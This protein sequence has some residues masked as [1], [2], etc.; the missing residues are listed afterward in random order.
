MSTIDVMGI[1][2]IRSFSPDRQEKITFFKPLTLIVGHNGAGKTTVIEC[3]KMACTGDLPPNVK[4]GQNFI[5]DPKVAGE[6]EVKAQIKLRFQDPSNVSFMVTRSFL[7]SQRR[8]NLQFKALDNALNILDPE[9]NEYSIL[10]QRC[11]NINQQI[12]LTMG[13][14]KA[15]LENVVFVHQEDS[16]WPLSEAANVKKRFDDIFAAT[17]YTKALEEFRKLKVKQTQEAKERRLKLETLKSYRDQ[18]MRLREAIEYSEKNAGAYRDTICKLNDEITDLDAKIQSLN[19]KLSQIARQRESNSSLKVKYDLLLSKNTEMRTLLE[20]KYSTDDL[21]TSVQD[22]EE[23]EAE[24]IPK[25]EILENEVNRADGEISEVQK[26]LHDLI[27]EREVLV[28]DIA[29]LTGE[30][31]SFKQSQNSRHAILSE[32]SKEIG[33]DIMLSNDLNEEEVK[34]VTGLVETSMQSLAESILQLKRSRQMEERVFQENIDA[35]NEKI[36]RIKEILRAKEESVKANDTKTLEIQQN[37]SNLQ[38][39]IGAQARSDNEVQLEMK[40]ISER[41]RRLEDELESRSWDTE[42]QKIDSSLQELGNNIQ[43]LRSDRSKIAAA[44][45]ESSR[46][47]FKIQELEKIKEEESNFRLLHA[48]RLAVLIGI[49]PSNVPKASEELV[50]IVQAKVNEREEYAENLRKRLEKLKHNVSCAENLHQSQHKD[51]NQ[52]EQEFSQIE[53][54]LKDMHSTV[55][56]D[57]LKLHISSLSNRKNIK[58]KEYHFNEASR[59]ILEKEKQYAID[60]KACLACNRDFQSTEERNQFTQEKD[61][62]ISKLP[63]KITKA[64][65]ELSDL[66]KQINDLILVEPDARRYNELKLSIAGLKDALKSSSDNLKKAKSASDLAEESMEKA[67]VSLKESNVIFHEVVLPWSRLLKDIHSRE[68]DCSTIQGTFELEQGSKSIEDI[69]QELTI[70]D[71]KRLEVQQT[72]DRVSS[73]YAE[74]SKKVIDERNLLH[75]VQTSFKERATAIESEL[76]LKE[77]LEELLSASEILAIEAAESNFQLQGFEKDRSNLIQER[78]S[79]VSRLDSELK[80]LEDKQRSLE[81]KSSHLASLNQSIAGQDPKKTIKDMEE[82]LKRIETKKLALETQ[83]KDLRNEIEDKRTEGN[84]AKQFLIQVQEILKLKKGE[85]EIEDIQAQ[86]ER[87]GF[88]LSFFEQEKGLK[89]EINSLSE[90][91]SSKKSEADMA[92]GSLAA[93]FEAAN[94]SRSRLSGAEYQDIDS[95]CYRHVTEVQT[96]EIAT[97]DIERYH[98]ALERALLSFH[99]TKMADINKTIKELWQK[100]YRGVDIDYIQIKADTDSTASSRSSY[101]YRVVMYVGGAELDMRGRC[102]AGQRVLSCLIIRLA[103]AETFCLNCGILALDEPTTNLDADNAASLAESLKSLML[104]RRDFESF[105]LVVITHD[106]EFARRLGSREFIETI[107][108]ITKDENQHSRIMME[109]IS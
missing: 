67:K 15:I 38:K 73:S 89:K 32:L 18:A 100:T 106:E 11:S 101:N 58:S 44:G 63:E 59:E 45:E 64:K 91:R 10:P 104:A 29:R 109:S 34:S 66:E 4:S 36:S 74:L 103:L 9:T 28:R 39:V 46:L 62:E 72:R 71:A 85:K 90:I 57:A 94:D 56:P 92:A 17:K 70:L 23:Y 31:K 65:L 80:N 68:Q 24:L 35:L 41:L 25:M 93:S 12:P 14:S 50:S 16:N 55:D 86:L 22:L 81:V 77:D 8:K 37:L 13:V 33:L 105:Q 49:T 5:H 48:S 6:T 76:K 51:L 21:E 82:N 60:C 75:Q 43:R 84:D 61:R 42:L 69:D 47:R 53:R 99:A 7:L 79:F 87:N 26:E 2:G 3:L 20:D 30:S 78:S 83:E 95:K 102:S 54:R 88:D 108:R 40:Q 1:K 97:S 27:P 107:W 52:A 96:M 98:K 19:S